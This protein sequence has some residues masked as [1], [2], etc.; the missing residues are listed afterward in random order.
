VT[1]HAGTQLL[2][3]WPCSCPWS[4]LTCVSKVLPMLITLCDPIPIFRS[5]QCPVLLSPV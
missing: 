2:C 1:L 4:F 3:G 5:V